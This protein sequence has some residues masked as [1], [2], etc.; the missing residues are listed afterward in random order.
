MPNSRTFICATTISL[1]RTGKNAREPSDHVPT[2]LTAELNTNRW[3]EL[4]LLLLPLGDDRATALLSSVIRQASASSLACA[5]HYFLTQH[6]HNFFLFDDGSQPQL[7]IRIRALFESDPHDRPLSEAAAGAP[8]AA[9]LRCRHR[10]HRRVCR[11]LV[12]APMPSKPSKRSQPDSSKLRGRRLHRLQG[13][14]RRPC[15]R[16]RREVRRHASEQ[17]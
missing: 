14:D 13:G 8:A 5:P 16:D 3:M 9:A 4:L 11:P 6:T 2:L 12:Q 10:R 17:L 15:G 7:P 1:H